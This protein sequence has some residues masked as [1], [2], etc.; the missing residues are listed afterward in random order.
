MRQLKPAARYAI[1]LGVIILFAGTTMPAATIQSEFTLV[2]TIQLK[3]V[4]GGLDH[5]IVDNKNQRLFLANKAN[6]TLDIVDL[7]TGALIQQV[8]GQQGVQGVAYAAD[9]DRIFTT[10]GSGGFCNVFDGKDYKLLKTIKFKDDADNVRYLARTHT[11]YVAH[12]ENALGV[13][14]ANSFDVRAD[15]KLPASAEG[16]QPESV[17]PRLYLTTPQPSQVVVVDTDKNEVIGR[18]PVKGAGKAYAVAVDEPT[19]RLFVACRKS[20]AV[21][22]LDSESGKEITRIAIPDGVDDIMYDAERKRILTSCGEGFVAVIKVVDANHYELVEKLPTVKDAKT[23]YFS[24]SDGKL[25]VAVPRQAG[26]D[27]PEI[28]VYQHQKQ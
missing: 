15:I 2:Q 12:A 23:C 3:G 24:P 16:L 19:Q 7:K 20:P 8:E 5:V 18:F 1:V 4:E 11:V 27:S 14:D 13:I 21:V 9:L 25:Y 28:R 17:R 10:L 26:K 22:V 6:N